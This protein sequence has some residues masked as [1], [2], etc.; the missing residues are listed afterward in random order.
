MPFAETAAIALAALLFG[1][2]GIWRLTR[3]LRP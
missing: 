1:L 3:K 2:I